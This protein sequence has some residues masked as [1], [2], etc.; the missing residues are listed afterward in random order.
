VEELCRVEHPDSR[1]IEPLRTSR[2][3]RTEELR[4]ELRIVVDIDERVSAA[5]A[6]AAE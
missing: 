4:D 5:Q 2:C 3:F 1:Q 6:I